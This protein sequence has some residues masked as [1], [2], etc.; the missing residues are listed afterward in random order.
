MTIPPSPG[1]PPDPGPF[2]GGSVLGGRYVLDRCVADD[3]LTERWTASDRVLA[4]GVM[5]EALSPRSAPGAREAFLAAVAAAARLI[6]PG[7]VSTYDSGVAMGVTSGAPNPSPASGLPYVVTERPRGTSLAEVVSRQGALPATRVV[8]IGRQLARALEAAHRAGVAHTGIEPATVL[9]AEDD[10]VKLA[11]FAACGARARLRGV[12]PEA[13]AVD[14]RDLAATLA[15]ALVGADASRPVSPRQHRPHTPVALDRVLMDAQTGAIPD[16]SGLAAALE[17]LDVT[18]DA[19]P[20]MVR[21]RTPILGTPA[22]P[23]RRVARGARPDGIGPVGDGT[24]P[25]RPGG[26]DSAVLTTGRAPSRAGSRSGTIGGIVVGLLLL[27]A[28]AV[29]AFVLSGRGGTP[30]A[31]GPTSSTVVG[32]GRAGLLGIVGGHSFNPLSPDDPTKRENE[33][34]VPRL[35]DGDP[36]TT[37]STAQYT[38]RNFGNLKTGTGVYVQLDHSHTLHQLTITSPTRGWALNVY[39]AAEPGTDLAA[40]GAPIA[41]PVTVTAD[42]TQIDLAGAKGAAVLVWITQLGDSPPFHV[43]IGELALR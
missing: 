16:A 32:T 33:A 15:V 8:P 37:W 24:R 9:L 40:W 38:T 11:R 30:I 39:A 43:E 6:H 14:V 7:I 5:V 17:G 13:M 2:S 25:S 4:R 28:V 36:A 23:G 18:D 20:E 31:V 21:E 19:E 3:G 35:Y 12:A 27:V 1:Q 22:V 10:R 26:R 34:L 41:G 29:A 42:V